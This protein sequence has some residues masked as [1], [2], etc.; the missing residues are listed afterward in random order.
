MLAFVYLCIDPLH[1]IYD[2]IA[3]TKSSPFKNVCAR[4]FNNLKFWL[5]SLNRKCIK[6]DSFLLK[7][8]SANESRM[9]IKWAKSV[10]EFLIFIIIIFYLELSLIN[11]HYGQW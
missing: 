1:F 2:K 8:F 10:S 9:T 4:Y 6:A 3:I 5:I 7:M 11:L